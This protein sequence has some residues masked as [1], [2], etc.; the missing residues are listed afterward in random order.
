MADH[1]WVR[2]PDVPQDPAQSAREYPVW[3]RD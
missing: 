1:D 2:V 3:G